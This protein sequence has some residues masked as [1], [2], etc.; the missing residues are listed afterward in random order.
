VGAFFLAVG[1]G[2][3]ALDELNGRPLRTGIPTRLLQAVAALSLA[4]AL[5]LGG[6]AAT[7]M[8][9]KLV[10]FVIVGAVAVVTYNLEWFRGLVHTD[11]VFAAMW[12]AFPVL[13]AYF[14]QA[15]RVDAVVLAAAGGAFALSYAQRAL[16]TQ[17][18][19]LRRR[20]ERVEGAIVFKDGSVGSLEVSVLL[21]PL[22][23]ALR[24]MSWGVVALAFALVAARLAS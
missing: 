10:P 7:Q 24:A 6:F 21:K 13:A 2:A 18:R 8:G 19:A 14:T 15:E 4:G 1:I 12:G 5:A 17:A 20:V 16:S 3:H 22:E 9:L 11:V 23:V